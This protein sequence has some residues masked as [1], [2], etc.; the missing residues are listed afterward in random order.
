MQTNVDVGQ[1]EG[2]RLS[3]YDAK[4]PSLPE[5]VKQTTVGLVITPAIVPGEALSPSVRYQLSNNI[6][7][8]FWGTP[9]AV[10]EDA[11]MLPNE[12]RH[13]TQVLI[14]N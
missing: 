2:K 3:L 6:C 11:H 14:T 5:S 4:L 9:A 13:L 12:Y 1:G 8:L 10:H 7:C